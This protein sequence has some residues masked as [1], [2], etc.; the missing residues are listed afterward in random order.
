MQQSNAANQLIQ[1]TDWKSGICGGFLITAIAGFEIALLFIPAPLFPII[2]H[3]CASH[4]I[5]IITEFNFE[6]R[7]KCQMSVDQVLQIAFRVQRIS[8][9]TI[10]DLHRKLMSALKNCSHSNSLP[11][12]AFG[13]KCRELRCRILDNNSSQKRLFVCT[14]VLDAQCG[15]GLH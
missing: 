7:R 3:D 2:L 14:P 5:P 11:N 9:F 15:E 8:A 13:T 10:S 4:N 1:H 12:S 6:L